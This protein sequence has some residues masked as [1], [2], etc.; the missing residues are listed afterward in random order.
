MLSL[1][2]R[3][4]LQ[5]KRYYCT[6]RFDKPPII[7]QLFKKPNLEV[8]GE[9][10]SLGEEFIETNFNNLGKST[11]YPMKVSYPFL[12]VQPE[13]CPNMWLLFSK[14]EKDTPNIVKALGLNPDKDISRL[15]VTISSEDS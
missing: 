14:H 2:R 13:S 11:L 5:Q 1:T 15:D 10:Q 7:H 8:N 12:V 6:S 9:I 4:L 3:C